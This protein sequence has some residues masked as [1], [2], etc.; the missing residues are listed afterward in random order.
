MAHLQATKLEKTLASF[1]SYTCKYIDVVY[2]LH[3]LSSYL[4]FINS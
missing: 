4:L 2:T 1:T 3:S